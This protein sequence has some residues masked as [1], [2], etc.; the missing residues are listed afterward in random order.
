[1]TRASRL[2]MLSVRRIADT[3]RRIP[4]PPKPSLRIAHYKGIHSYSLSFGMG[5]YLELSWDGRHRPYV[6]VYV[7]KTFGQFPRGYP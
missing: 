6:R 7:N 3:T 1:M 4:R 2:V 5:L